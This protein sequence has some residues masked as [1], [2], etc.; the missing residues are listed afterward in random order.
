MKS[1]SPISII[2][3]VVF[4]IGLWLLARAYDFVAHSTKTIGNVVALNK[5][6]TDDGTFFHP[7]V[8]F[9]DTS[10][11]VHTQETSSG[12]SLSRFKVGDRV[13]I[14]YSTATLRRVEVDNFESIWVFPLFFIGG[15]T[16]FIV[17]H[18]R[19][20]R[21]MEVEKTRAA[22]DNPHRVA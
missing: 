21:K 16:L 8:A 7:V 6:D 20:V 11:I 9:T 1:R 14:R 5:E 19:W 22:A 15:G 17:K 13:A 4:V 3:C 2:G 18:Y 12:S 10:G